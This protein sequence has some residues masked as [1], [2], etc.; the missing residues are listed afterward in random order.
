MYLLNTSQVAWLQRP[1]F[2]LGSSN[3]GS[4]NHCGIEL[5]YKSLTTNTS[6]SPGVQVNISPLFREE[7]I[8]A[9]GLHQYRIKNPIEL[10]NE[11]RTD[12]WTKLCDFLTN[13]NE[14]DTLTKVRVM[15][16][17]RSLCFH[18]AVLEY[19]PRMSASEISSSSEMA[20][21][22]WCRAVS[23]RFIH[24]DYSKTPDFDEI[25]NIATSAPHQSRTRINAALLLVVEY[26][27]SSK[28]VENAEFWRSCAEKIIQEIKPELNDFEYN[29]LISVYYRSVSF[30]PFLH[31]DKD[32]LIKEMD[33]CEFHGKNLVCESEHQQI[34]ARENFNLLMESRAKEALWL[35]DVDLAEERTR[36]L[37][38][39]EP[40]DPRY[41]L[42]LGE[43]LIKQ[44]RIEE[45][46]KIYR[47]AARLGPPGTEIAWFMAGQCHE[48]LNEL[49]IACDCYLAS[50]QLDPE[51]ISSL[52][53]LTEL[54]PKISSIHLK[55]W[56]IA[57]LTE[58]E[59]QRNII[60]SQT[61]N[62]YIP[63]S[64]SE[65]KVAGQKAF[66]ARS[67]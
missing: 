17:L 26:A 39:R 1:Y 21:L 32:R 16:L 28:D 60:A 36:L 46:L 41:H 67:H 45:A 33:L 25:E 18:E 40:L 19:V 48:S 51:A 24:Y 66:L 42:E 47:S 30:V 12:R 54:A 34:V 8:R 31:K 55:S 23:N 22:A 10:P 44:H 65:L 29:L 62:Y 9:T 59:K 38:E 35:G 6:I 63:A 14:L 5:T 2:D 53:K 50:L 13:Y 56:S 61:S 15:N 57:R 7:L 20:A 4:V 64:S 11:L 52:E 3:T 27:N 43:I 58:L 37:V 49:D